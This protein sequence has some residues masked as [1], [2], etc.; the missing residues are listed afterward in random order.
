MSY[1]LLQAG[2][3]LAVLLSMALG[4]RVVWLFARCDKACMPEDV[5]DAFRPSSVKKKRNLVCIFLAI[6]CVLSLFTLEGRRQRGSRFIALVYPE[7]S[8]GLN[9]NGSRYNMSDILSDEILERAIAYGGFDGLTAEDLKSALD[10]RTIDKEEPGKKNGVVNPSG[11]NNG[12]AISG[13]NEEKTEEG[14]VSTQF[15]LEFTSNGRTGGLDGEEVVSAITKA[16]KDWFIEQY[17]V[18]TDVLNISFDDMEEYD[19]P[20]LR[21]YFRGQLN[22]ITNFA[23]TYSG[24][25]RSFTSEQAGASFWEL[26]QKGWNIY[27]TS[28]EDFHSYVLSFGLS[29][30]KEEYLSKIRHTHIDLCRG[31]RDNIQAYDVR[32]DAIN[33]YDED[34]AAVVYVPTYDTDN[35]FYM[36]KTKI[37]I[38]HFSENADQQSAYASG[39]LSE[40]LDEDYLIGQLSKNA[41]KGGHDE[42]ADAQIE[43]LKSQI[44]D[45]AADMRKAVQDYEDTVT[46]GYI[47]VSKPKQSISIEIAAVLSLSLCIV[48]LIYCRKALF[49]LYRQVESQRGG[50]PE[51]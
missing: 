38:D 9:P 35:T 34:M 20:E 16:Y 51:R 33:R 27:N 43:L 47:S 23:K 45:L 37:G 6:V 31:Y 21:D 29:K 49:G 36:S 39:R 7:A 4:L 3:I 28:L 44:L 8:S 22:K 2:K 32:I 30:D 11:N 25:N 17:A 41:E 12:S 24:K 19:Y 18:N 13:L 46:N 42:K 1:W 26:G 5:V 40:I 15:L 50:N 48:F 14:L 10:I